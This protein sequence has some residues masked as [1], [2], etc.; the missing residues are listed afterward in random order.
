VGI[1]GADLCVRPGYPVHPENCA[2]ALPAAARQFDDA[3]LT[4]PVV[5][6]PGDFTDPDAPA[7]ETL[8]AACAEAGVPAV[9]LG[10]WRW[11]HEPGYWPL[12]AECRRKMEGFA[13]L[14]DK[15][16]VRA[17]VHNHSGHTMGLHSTAAMSLVRDL[18]PAHVGI[19]TDVGHLALVG[20]PIPMALDIAWDYIELFALKDLLWQKDIGR[21]EA[22]RKLRV[23]PFGHGLVEWGRFIDELQARDYDGAL[24]FHCEYS[25]YPPEA[26][27]DQAALDVRFFRAL[28]A[29]RA[30]G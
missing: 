30:A 24:S 7:A 20:E 11:E 15:H 8:F 6:A 18:D 16:G 28:W 5:T 12:L 23:V 13:A 27:L 3:G 14:A 1:D 4:I 10:Y 29:E 2:R 9:K 19:F 26:V 17:C 22:E 25:G 21:L